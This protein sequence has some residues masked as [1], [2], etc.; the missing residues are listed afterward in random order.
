MEHEVGY[1]RVRNGFGRDFVAPFFK[2]HLGIT[3]HTARSCNFVTKV[4]NTP[5][6]VLVELDQRLERAHRRLIQNSSSTV[7]QEN[8]GLIAI[9]ELRGMI[10]RTPEE[11]WF[12]LQPVAIVNR[13][14]RT[15]INA[16]AKHRIQIAV[17]QFPVSLIGDDA[18]IADK[19]QGLQ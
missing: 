4:D 8:A 12:L 3:Q 2:D 19:T 5:E 6:N 17:S 15:D 13:Y 7:R 10:G 9:S 18:E 11:H 16:Y 1:R 14:A